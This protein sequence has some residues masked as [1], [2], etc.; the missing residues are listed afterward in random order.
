MVKVNN[1]SMGTEHRGQ[2]Q[3]YVDATVG[4]G[5]ANKQPPA[6]GADNTSSLTGLPWPQGKVTP[7]IDWSSHV[8]APSVVHKKHFTPT[9]TQIGSLQPTPV[10]HHATFEKAKPVPSVRY[11]QAPMLVGE[12]GRGS[13]ID[14]RPPSSVSTFSMAEKQSALLRDG[15]QRLAQRMASTRAW[16][17]N[18]STRSDV[19]AVPDGYLTSTL[20]SYQPR[21]AADMQQ[22]RLRGFTTSSFVNCDPLNSA[23]QRCPTA[24]LDGGSSLH[25]QRYIGLRDS[26]GSRRLLDT[27]ATAPPFALGTSDTAPLPPPPVARKFVSS[28]PTTRNTDTVRDMQAGEVDPKAS[29]IE[30]KPWPA[31]AGVTTKHR[32]PCAMDIHYGM[33]RFQEHKITQA[34]EQAARTAALYSM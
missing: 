33:M 17:A 19:S 31:E 12:M 28:Q 32:R 14:E 3:L 34:K 13:G 7:S 20:A 11:L 6:L 15:E 23:P 8:W 2:Y 25:S 29:A 22:H 30:R 21:P 10:H 9:S 4:V 18:R 5:T 27:G 24:P 26:D 16:T 1:L